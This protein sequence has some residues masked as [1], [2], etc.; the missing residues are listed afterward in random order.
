MHSVWGSQVSRQPNNPYATESSLVLGNTQ[1]LCL[2]R[3]VF[4]ESLGISRRAVPSEQ[5][6]SIPDRISTVAPTHTRTI[7]P[8][9][10]LLRHTV[11]NHTQSLSGG[12]RHVIDRIPSMLLRAH[13]YR[14]NTHECSRR[15]C[16]G[17]STSQSDVQMDE[18]HPSGKSSH[19]ISGPAKRAACNRYTYPRE[20]YH[21]YTRFESPCETMELEK[22]RLL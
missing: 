15:K 7:R 19:C 16:I 22:S 20:W 17:E 5:H 13:S 9:W 8:F 10:V 14:V 11:S 21:F 1:V 12:G 4:R 2:G 18:D 6:A 3:L